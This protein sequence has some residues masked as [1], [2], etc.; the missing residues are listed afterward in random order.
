MTRAQFVTMIAMAESADKV[1]ATGDHGLASGE[2]QMH[3]DWRLDY[4]P[5]W[6]WEVLALLDRYAL[7]HFIVFDHSGAKRVPITARALADIYNLGHSAGDPQYDV[8]C[9]RALQ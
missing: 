9:L 4:W 3:V 6:A 7:E 5:F 1:K 8:R 2:F